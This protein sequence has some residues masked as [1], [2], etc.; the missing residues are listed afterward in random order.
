[1]ATKEKTQSNGVAKRT[2]TTQK[3]AVKAHIAQKAENK[4]T[5]KEAVAP[6]PQPAPPKTLDERLSSFE[7]MK[8][9]ANQRERLNSTLSN[10]NRFKYQNSDSC[11]FLLRDDNGQ[12]FKT[13]NNNLIQLVTDV[14]QDKLSTRKTEIE[15]QILTFDL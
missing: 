8:G 14:L 10:L 4:A 12:E 13:T 1:M 7:R 5:A 3:Q 11:V 15:Q 6:S 9:L 2:A